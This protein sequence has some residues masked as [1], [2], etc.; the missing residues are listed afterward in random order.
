[1]SC[2]RIQSEPDFSVL[3]QKLDGEYRSSTISWSPVSSS[4]RDSRTAMQ[5]SSGFISHNSLTQALLRGY[6]PC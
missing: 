6:H 2:Q 5:I 4:R 3:N 1:M